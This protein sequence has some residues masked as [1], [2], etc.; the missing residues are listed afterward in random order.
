MAY[1]KLAKKYHPDLNPGDATATQKFRSV[2]EAYEILSDPAKR[3]NY[4]QY[5]SSSNS[6]SSSSSNSSSSGGRQTQRGSPF[7]FDNMASNAGNPFPSSE[8]M[9]RHYRQVFA[10]LQGD[11][12]IIAEAITEYVN[13]LKDDAST[14]YDGAKRG[15]FAPMLDAVSRNKVPVAIAF[16]LFAV[17]RFPA[18]IIPASAMLA[19]GAVRFAVSNPK[20]A[21]ALGGVIW[22]YVVEKAKEQ[23][24]KK[25]EEEATRGDRGNDAEKSKKTGWKTRRK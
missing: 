22:Q 12:A 11:A 3:K 6:S 2:T 20:G 21:V 8:E 4:D 7:D 18:L 9:D 13:S 19:K 23:N 15:D 25:V 14:S 1:Y 10:E 5:G 24:R 17:V 16:S